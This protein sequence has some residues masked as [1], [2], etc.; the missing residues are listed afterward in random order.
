[1]HEQK[2]ANTAEEWFHIQ[3]GGNVIEV[4]DADTKRVDWHFF[5]ADDS[6]DGEHWYY[7]KNKK[8][9]AK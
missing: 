9:A 1:M 2:K 3:S 5:S 8:S 7:F 6:S 4:T